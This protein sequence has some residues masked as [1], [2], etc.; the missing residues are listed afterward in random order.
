VGGGIQ[1]KLIEEE[2]QQY[3]NFLCQQEY[4]RKLSSVAGDGDENNNDN[5]DDGN[6]TTNTIDDEADECDNKEEPPTQAEAF[7]VNVGLF[8][9]Q[10]A[11]NKNS[12]QSGRGPSIQQTIDTAHQHTRV[13]FTR[14]YT[15]TKQLFICITLPLIIALFGAFDGNGATQY[16][17]I[18]NPGFT[19]N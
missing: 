5:D 7:A 6:D 10:G 17:S 4:S 8:A 18:P 14:S 9:G 13:N 11:D 15:T 16:A 1:A 2:L 19:G 3:R 12:N